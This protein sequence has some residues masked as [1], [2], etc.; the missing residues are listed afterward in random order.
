MALLEGDYDPAFLA[1]LVDHKREELELEYKAWMDLSDHEARA[2]IAKHICA[3]A[4]HGGGWLIF[5]IDDNGH[6]AEPHPPDLSAYKQDAINGIAAKYLAPTVQC[7]VLV[8]TSKLTGRKYPVVRVPSHGTTPVCA[9]A[10]GPVVNKNV[11]GIVKGVHYQRTPG[12]Q[13]VPIDGPEMWR[14]LIHRCVVNERQTLLASINRL[15]DRPEP[16][17]QSAALDSLIDDA[18]ARW[19]EVVLPSGWPVD[20]KANR[21]VFA[22]RLLN[23]TGDPPTSLSLEKLR[24]G[25]RTASNAADTAVRQ[26]WTFFFN[27][28]N[29]QHR[30]RVRL[31][32]GD[33]EGYEAGMIASDGQ[34]LSIPSLWRAAADGSGYEVRL[35]RE[36]STWVISAVNE[37][38]SRKW[39]AGAFLSPR[40]QAT[41][42]CQF[43]I[44]VRAFASHFP[45]AE[46]V[47]IAADFV[48]LNGRDVDDPHSGVFYS[49]DRKSVT[50][51]RRPKWKMSVEALAGDGVFDAAAK[52]L[53]PVFRLFDGF[54]VPAPFVK[55]AVEEL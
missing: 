33:V 10:N 44:F 25:I 48:G 5:G 21:V 11:V 41:R 45:D 22:F 3:L 47:E 42:M 24:Q 53:T 40:L 17:A 32:K 14:E 46:Q 34:Y 8:A 43:I 50:D 52:L 30:P 27:D 38:R 20:P 18:S 54:D 13:S 29:E 19:N 37:R 55:K 28:G 35:Q 31:M 6:G 26:G 9:K 23:G 12:P 1:G 2:K 15:F 16:V 49:R 39:A 51:S 36:D 4:N 7:S